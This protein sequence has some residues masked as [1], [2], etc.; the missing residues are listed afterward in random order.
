[1]RSLTS[2]TSAPSLVIAGDVPAAAL[3]VPAGAVPSL[4]QS[5]AARVEE[6]HG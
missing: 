3:T 1:M 4:W 6:A 5:I 2:L